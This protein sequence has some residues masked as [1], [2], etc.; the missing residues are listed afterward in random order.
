MSLFV[1][2]MQTV[3][4]TAAGDG[5][6][7]ADDA[8]RHLGD[9]QS[10]GSRRRDSTSHLCNP[11]VLSM[12]FERSERLSRHRHHRSNA[13]LI[14]DGRALAIFGGIQATTLS[15]TEGNSVSS[16]F[17]MVPIPDQIHV[18]K[19]CDIGGTTFETGVCVPLVTHRVT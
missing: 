12:T 2:G 17:A 6:A 16:S 1:T 15:I 5:S 9:A 19:S 4:S 14:S 7:T 8:R 18:L 13:F 11:T 3:L 10:V